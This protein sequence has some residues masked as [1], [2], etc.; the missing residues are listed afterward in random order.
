MSPCLWLSGG[1]ALAGVSARCGCGLVL[2]TCQELGDPAEQCPALVRAHRPGPVREGSWLCSG[3]RDRALQGHSALG[4]QRL[5]LVGRGRSQCDGVSVW[6]RHAAGDLLVWSVC[7]VPP[8]S[9]GPVG[10]SRS[11]ALCEVA[12]A[13]AH[14]QGLS[15]VGV[16]LPTMCGG[17]GPHERSLQSGA[18]A[19]V[20]GQAATQS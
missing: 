7:P 1:V 19:S 8:P 14:R 4:F 15:G 3:G 5:F 9:V 6:H 13:T 18:C 12:G 2:L 16:A 10:K 20:M 11:A 17:L